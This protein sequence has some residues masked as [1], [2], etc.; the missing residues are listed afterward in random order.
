MAPRDLLGFPNARR[1]KPK[2]VFTGGLR[3]WWRD[4]NGDILE[5]DSRHGTVERYNHRGEH[6]GEFSAETGKQLNQAD[7]ARKVEP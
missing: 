3:P 6:L 1:T 2:T 7:P 4:G 5:L